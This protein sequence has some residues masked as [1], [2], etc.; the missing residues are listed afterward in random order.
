MTE[1]ILVVE[2]NADNMKLVQWMLEDEGYEMIGVETGERALAALSS[3]PFALVLTD[4]SLPGMDGKELTRR[5]RNEE[6]WNGL[7][8]V[9]VTGVVATIAYR[10]LW[11]PVESDGRLET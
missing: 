2:D 11:R 7:P 3:Q 4:I 9:A 5:I 8:I 10:C 1:P 6:R